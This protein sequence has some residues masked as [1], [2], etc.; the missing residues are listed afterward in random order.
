MRF[1]GPLQPNSVMIVFI[2]SIVIIIIVIVMIIAILI[3]LFIC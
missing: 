1:W 2:R 3:L